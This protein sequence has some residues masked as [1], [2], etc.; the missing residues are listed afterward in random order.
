MA[1][2]LGASAKTA[3]PPS[4]SVHDIAKAGLPHEVEGAHGSRRRARPPA[5][6]SRRPWR[7]HGGPSQRGRSP[8]PVEEAVIVQAATTPCRV[9]APEH[10]ASRWPGPR[11]VTSSACATSSRVRLTRHPGRWTSEKVYAMQAGRE[12]RVMVQPGAIDDDAAVVL[13]HEIAREI[14]KELEYPGQIKV[15]VIRE[16]RAIELRPLSAGGRVRPPVRGRPRPRGGARR[17]R[18]AAGA[19]SRSPA[20]RGTPGRPPASPARPSPRPRPPSP[21]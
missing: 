14:E 11:S 1:D 9:P 10:A 12:I 5:L 19:R 20:R 8:R 18:D 13:S 15:T 6:R 7:R 3:A 2:E 17:R 21:A 4:R 16:S